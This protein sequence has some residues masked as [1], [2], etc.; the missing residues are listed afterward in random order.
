MYGDLCEKLGVGSYRR[1]PVLSVSPGKGGLNRA[2]KSNLSQFLPEWLDGNVGPIQCMGTGD[3]TAQVTPKEFVEKM[4]ASSDIDVVLGVGTGVSTD[5]TAD[6]GRKITGVRYTG[7]SDGAEEILPCDTVVV[8]AG[9]WS[10]MVEEWFGGVISAPM[11]G[12]KSTSVV[13]KAPEDGAV[14]ATALFCGED[15]R[16]GTHLEVYPRPDGSIYLCGIGGSDY[17]QKGELMQGAYREQCDANE[18]RV[19]AASKAFREMSASYKKSGEL[20]KVQA[21]MRPCPPDAKPYMGAIPGYE[22]AY[23]NAGHNCW[24]IAWAPACG[25]AMAELILEGS[26]SCVDLSPFDPSR[27][28]PDRKKAGR[29]RKRGVTNVG[30]QW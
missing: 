11:E 28:T 9:P 19:T 2:R 21:C 6:D 16:F 18:S 29:G 27:F 10:C 24:G 5:P 12:V 20:E 7:R 25:K 17:V 3:D 14:D 13:W 15:D 1:L 23:V 4:I 8:S 22:G 30:E 26:S